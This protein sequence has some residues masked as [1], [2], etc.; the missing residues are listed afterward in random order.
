[1]H[2]HLHAR[3]GCEILDELLQQLRIIDNIAAYLNNLYHSDFKIS[4]RTVWAET[5]RFAASGITSD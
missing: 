4:F 1:M 3:H 2:K 5:T